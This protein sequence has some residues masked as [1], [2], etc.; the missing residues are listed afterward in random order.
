M[1][2]ARELTAASREWCG[3]EVDVDAKQIV[4]RGRAAELAEWLRFVEE[5]EG[6]AEQVD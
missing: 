3:F 6:T 2:L 4:D 5:A 1:D